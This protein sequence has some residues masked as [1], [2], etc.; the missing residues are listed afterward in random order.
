[1]PSDIADS[2]SLE[3]LLESIRADD[4]G[5]ARMLLEHDPALK[6]QLNEPIGPF[7]SPALSSARSRDMVDLL[8]AAG[9]DI[10]GKSR[11]WAG[12][13]GFLHTA[14]LALAEY[15]VERGAAVDVHAAARLGLLDRLE[16]LL[17]DDP[18]AVHARGGD[19]QTP[20]HFARSVE[21]AAYLLD[22]GADIDA[23]D[24]DHESTPAQ[25]MVGERQDV[26]RYLV[27]RG[28]ATDILLVAALGDLDRVRQHLDAAPECIRT[29]VSAEF[30]PMANPRAGGKIYQWTLGYRA[31]PY[32]VA[33]KFGHTDVLELLM[34]RS[35]PEARLIATCWLHDGTAV[36]AL[37]AEH[38]DLAG[39]T[40]A[41][42]RDE[43]AHAARNNDTQA[44]LLMLQAGLP[45]NGRGQHRATALHW[46]AWHGNLELVR[47]LLRE[48]AP[49]ENADN[50]FHSTPLG[51]AIHGSE[52]G[53]H[54]QSGDYPAVVS[55]LLEAGAERPTTPAANKTIDSLLARHDKRGK[56]IERGSITAGQAEHQDQ[57]PDA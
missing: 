22:R 29:N 9:A 54:R 51:W 34:D 56:G 28:C 5:L 12:G 43:L 42:D 21:I 16:E 39:Q 50:D 45:I 27:E 46:A 24:I 11:W 4:V 13:F 38:A 3:R 41:A 35:P 47:A 40:A 19:G 23:R 53:W 36:S 17:S 20:L 8:L 57:A 7:D 49:L 26:A 48:H 1:M 2:S 37:I 33:A 31:T 15:A 52:H 44:A 25:W 10:D 32:Q 55:A 18:A 14:D 6:A 30:F